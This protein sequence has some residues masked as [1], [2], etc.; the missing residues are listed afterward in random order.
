MARHN[1]LGLDGEEQAC[2]YLT[3]KGYRIVHRNWRSGRHELDIV[4]TDG[5]E[6]VFIEVKTRK[7]T[8]FGKPEDAVS[9]YKIRSIITAA[10]NYLRIFRID[11][12]VRFDVIAIISDGRQFK[13]KH[14]EE[15]FHSPI[16]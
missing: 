11:N 5:E 14:Y 2:R 15:A 4:A 16:W 12:P 8:E 13:I 10:D 3:A 6:Y 1:E 7:G 9:N